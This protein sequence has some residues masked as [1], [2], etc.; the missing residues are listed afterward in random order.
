MDNSWVWKLLWSTSR[1][2]GDSLTHRKVGVCE[3][4]TANQQQMIFARSWTMTN[5]LIGTQGKVLPKNEIESSG[6]S[7]LYGEAS[8][9]QPRNNSNRH[10]AIPTNGR[11]SL[12]PKTGTLLSI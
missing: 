12:L 7:K 5:A 11:P 8:L 3:W 2:F 9:T 6:V 4:L 10:S 1:T